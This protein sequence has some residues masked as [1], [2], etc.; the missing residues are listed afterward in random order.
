MTEP[1]QPVAGAGLQADPASASASASASTSDPDP[2]GFT[3]TAA[4]LDDELVL[5]DKEGESCLLNMTQIQEII[6]FFVF[7][8]FSEPLGKLRDYTGGFFWR[9]EQISSRCFC[10]FDF[11]LFY[12][13]F[14]SYYFILFLYFVLFL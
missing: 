3:D 4:R 7:S 8:F 13:F 1:E 2:A 5:V 14:H 6:I 11:F 10:G 9:Y 12:Y